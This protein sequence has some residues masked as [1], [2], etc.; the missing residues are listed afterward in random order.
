MAQA[1]LCGLE[2]DVREYQAGRV[3]PAQIMERQPRVPVR[4]GGVVLCG[5]VKVIGLVDW[6]EA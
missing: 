2:V 4:T 6:I 1:R 3:R 5:S